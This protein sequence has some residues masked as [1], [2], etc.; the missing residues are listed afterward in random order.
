MAKLSQK[1]IL[2]AGIVL[3][4]LLEVLAAFAFIVKTEFFQKHKLLADPTTYQAVFLTSD[5]VYFGH[6]TNLDSQYPILEDTYYVQLG[7]NSNKVVKLGENEPHGPQNH[8]VLNRDQILLWED[9]R[10]DSQIIRAIQ[11]I[12]TQK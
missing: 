6:L 9:L 5:Q 3:I 12:K 11:N 1:H 10:P 2:L 7:E 4:G 8:M